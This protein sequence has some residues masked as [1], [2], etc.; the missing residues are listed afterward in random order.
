M[1]T[2]IETIKQSRISHALRSNM[3]RLVAP[4]TMGQGYR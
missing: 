3:Q 4:S 1:L 2:K